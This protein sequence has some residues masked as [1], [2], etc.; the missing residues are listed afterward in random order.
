MRSILRG[1]A[2]ANLTAL[3][4]SSQSRPQPGVPGVEAFADGG[5]DPGLHRREP[6][7]EVFGECCHAADRPRLR[8]AEELLK[9][10]FVRG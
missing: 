9:R 8:L 7:I 1:V 4:R 6:G 10:V 5:P 3:Q 2:F